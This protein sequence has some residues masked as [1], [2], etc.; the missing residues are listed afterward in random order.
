MAAFAAVFCA[1]A[2]SSATALAAPAE[3]YLVKDINPGSDG[4]SPEMFTS[5]GGT[6]YFNA[7][8][9]SL[10]H[11]LWKSDGTPG[12]TSLVKDIYPGDDD[13]SPENLINVGGTLYFSAYDGINGNELWKSDGTP[14]GTTLVKDINPGITGS[15]P[16]KP[17]QRWRHP[18]L[19]RRRRHQRQRALE[20]RRHP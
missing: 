7:Y 2:L 14:D 11:E 6:V 20:I 8:E 1:V 12:G 10:G 15:Y 4:S 9:D 16:D 3:P 17:D 13:S 5:L 18:L 19:H